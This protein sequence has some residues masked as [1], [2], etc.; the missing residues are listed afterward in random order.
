[1]MIVI[2]GFLGLSYI[3]PTHV[4]ATD[5]SGTI[6]DGAGGPWTLAGSPYVVIGDVNVPAGEILT[7]EP[8]VQVRFN[9]E[10]SLLVDGSLYAVGIDANRINMTTNEFDPEEYPWYGINI[11][12]GGHAEIEYCVISYAYTAISIDS[13]SGNR[14][15]NN[16]LW[17]NMYLMDILSSPDNR[18]ESNN[19]S[20]SGGIYLY[21]SDDNVFENN[22]FHSNAGAVILNEA[23]GGTIIRNNIMSNSRAG[24]SIWN[25]G[26]VELSNNRFFDSGIE[27]DWEASN[28]HTIQNNTV[29]GK[30]LYYYKNCNGIVLDGIP[31]GQVIFA[32]C[33]NVEVRNLQLS[34][35]YVGVQ[36][37]RT[38]NAKVE[39]NRIWNVVDGIALE[40][41]D[42]NIIA[43]NNLTDNYRAIHVSLNSCDNT[44][45]NNY[46]DSNRNAVDLF[47]DSNGNIIANNTISNNEFEGIDIYFSSNDNVVRNNTV[48][49]NEYGIRLNW[50]T[51]RGVVEDN[52]IWNNDKAGIELYESEFNKISNNSLG[53]DG[54]FIWGKW[55]YQ[56]N[57]HEIPENNVL[58]GKPVYYR[59]NCSGLDI[60]GTSLGQLILGNCTNVLVR[61]LQIS[62]AYVG[63]EVAFSSGINITKNTISDTWSGIY[64]YGASGNEISSNQITSSPYGMYVWKSS[65]NITS[66]NLSHN[67]R[68]I[69]VHYSYFNNITE[70]DFWNNSVGVEIHYESSNR[71]FHNNFYYNENEPYEYPTTN[72]WNSSYPSGGNYWWDYSGVDQM[73]GSNQDVPGSDGIGDK[74]YVLRANSQDYYPLMA[75]FGI[76]ITL[77]VVSITSPADGTILTST[78]A[79][80]TGTASDAGG[81]GLERV[82]VSVNDGTW[83]NATGTSSWTT[84]VDLIP[85]LNTVKARAWDFAGNPSEPDSIVVTYD[86]PGNDP[87]VASFTISPTT[88]DLGTQF[89]LDASAS[90]DMEDL[91]SDLEVRW[92]WEDDGV[93][94]TSWSTTKTGQHQYGIPGNYTIRLEVKDTGGL[95]NS[96][97]RQVVVIAVDNQPPTC[98]I[99]APN[100][101]ETITGSYLIVGEASDSD[102]VVNFVEV[103]I[104]DSNWTF[105]G[106]AS[107]WTYQWD[108]TLADNGEHTIYARSY[109]GENYS[110][111][112]N[113]TVSV[114]NPTPPTD[115][116]RQ[117][118]W[119][120][121][122][123]TLAVV[124]VVVLLLIVFMFIRKRKRDREETDI[125]PPEE[126]L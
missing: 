31:V 71:V 108:T 18:I 90:S 93:W 3:M 112:V 64:F 73:S 49:N 59:K 53:N 113:V 116:E 46:I 20:D 105:A 114:N 78:P 82:E 91:S 98:M 44:I 115:Q 89:E 122:A 87:P 61:N 126:P 96:T 5:V 60:D 65:N 14:V 6:F 88:G 12:S 11:R 104:D 99:V 72:F 69:Y 37:R 2:S 28:S 103:R 101:G 62:N 109:D 55:P 23:S 79:A 74:P 17:N 100:P 97:T 25:S 19:M 16:T 123:I 57:T 27:I 110:A 95:M 92:D 84:S 63:I 85:G 45:E 107:D 120:W 21:H 86:P 121:I 54:I 1:M 56:Y 40:N 117:D 50:M 47:L 34:L 80:V 15:A 58:N 75:P 70:N 8:G 125:G 22:S 76:D 35:T 83:S 33:D 4:E 9:A 124:V 24:I 30:P 7:I 51:K 102:G 29:N 111:Q 43:S 119:I 81:S 10:F 67:G 118:D 94:D 42:R 13:S 52:D 36:L 38:T 66:N 77:P 41:S 106:G 32:Y 39:G 68:G 48:Y 26:G